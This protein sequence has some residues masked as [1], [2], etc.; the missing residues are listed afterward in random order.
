[1]NANQ[2]SWLKELAGEDQ[3]GT[4]LSILLRHDIGQ[5]TMEGT[6]KYLVTRLYEEKK[7]L[8][9]ENKR[10]ADVLKKHGLYTN[11][12]ILGNKSC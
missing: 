10:Y 12:L 11:E 7:Q 5:C 3:D 2:I 8:V 4:L 6:L 1:M 9:Q